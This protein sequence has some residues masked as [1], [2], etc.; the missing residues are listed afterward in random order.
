VSGFGHDDE[1]APITT[2]QFASLAEKAAK[3]KASELGWFAPLEEFGWI[4]TSS[5]RCGIL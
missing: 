3:E 2:R 1:K 5:D 4:S